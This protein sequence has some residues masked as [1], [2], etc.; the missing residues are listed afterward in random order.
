MSESE[1][2]QAA[3]ACPS[4]SPELETVHEVLSEGGGWATVRCTECAHVHKEQLPEAEA[5]ERSVVVSQG[6]ESVTATVEAPRGETIARGEE[7][8]VETEAAIH[9]VRITDLQVDAEKRVPEATVEDV[10]TIWTRA[11][12]NVGVSVTVNPGDGSDESHSVTAYVPG[13]Y[14]FVVGEEDT[15][16]DETFTVN[17]LVV[18]DDAVG[19]ERHKLDERGDAVP[20]KDLTRVYGETDGEARAWSGW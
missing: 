13:D 9:E 6:E 3:L 10:E 17:A 16:E 4:C 19:Y 20:A 15:V 5:V 2:E 11:V 1:A 7:F 14:E 8:V 18:R 12:D